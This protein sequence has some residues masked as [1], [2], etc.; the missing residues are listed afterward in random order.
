MHYLY[1]WEDG[2][3]PCEF[4]EF[5]TTLGVEVVPGK[6]DEF[7][8]VFSKELLPASNKLGRKLVAQWRTTIGSLEIVDLWAFEDLTHMQRFQEARQLSE[9]M[10]KASEKITAL[11]AR[12]TTRLMVPTPVSSLT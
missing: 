6:M 3:L 5:R 7:M 8:E 12:E 9:E 10:R 1:I 2:F 11:I 4:L